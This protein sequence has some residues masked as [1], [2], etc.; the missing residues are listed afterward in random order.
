MSKFRVP[1]TIRLKLVAG[2]GLGLMATVA[3]GLFTMHRMALMDVAAEEIRLNYFPSLMII[4]ELSSTV[5]KIRIV[6]ASTLLSRDAAERATE[7]KAFVELCEMYDGLRRS[8]E[9]LIDPGEEAANI[10]RIDGSWAAYR[11]LHE[12]T[13]AASRDSGNS[14]AL[15][16]F[17]GQSQTAFE[18]LGGL[19]DQ[20]VQYNSLQGANA[21]DAAHEHYQATSVATRVAVALAAL[22][23]LI[24]GFSL[25][26][27]VSAP[28]TRM[29][30]A[31][32]R[33]ADRDMSTEIPGVGRTDEIGGMAAAVQVFKEKMVEAEQLSAEQGRLKAE[34]AAGQKA[35]LEVTANGFEAK[36]GTLVST[37]ASCATELQGTAQSMSSAATHGTQQAA[38]V[39]AS[40]LD[41]SAGVQN[42]AAAAE[43][44]TASI[45]EIGRQISQ[46]SRIAQT[47]VGNA[48]HTDGVVRAL[49]EGAQKIGQVV[50]L[51]SN[52]A[53]QTNLL[54]L[55][56]TIEAARAGDAGKGFAVVASEV[57]S[58]AQQTARATEDIGAQIKHIQDATTQAVG[59]IG[60]ISSTIEEVS[61][62]VST[63][64]IAVEEQG[65]ATAEI[66]RNVQ[67][68][69]ASTQSVTATI[70]GVN[71]AASDTGAAAERVLEAASSLTRQA[72]TL[73]TEV[74]SFVESVRA[75]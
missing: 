1:L 32:R 45:V 20:E 53:A 39:A 57:K 71:Q 44:L 75:G 17:R 35:A 24:I 36:V 52:I 6:E 29:T 50:E 26:R 15:D 37:L 10:A 16:L 68:A 22:A 5:R 64:A 65:V 43:Q 48:R 60:G 34:T 41:A 13:M 62:I 19:L 69:A 59:A 46:S 58:L 27:A 56:A 49:A 7:E 30:A 33:L 3:L 31:M 47:A 74:G 51:I 67:Q 42:V 55:N 18:E 63:I 72:G 9:P 38:T 28:L 21:A 73:S 66:A 8:Y 11:R 54:A 4:G 25:V 40:A 70:A 12:Q 61:G 2:L 23:T 14:E